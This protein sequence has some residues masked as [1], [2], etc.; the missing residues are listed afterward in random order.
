MSNNVKAYS[1]VV[2]ALEYSPF[3][4]KIITVADVEAWLNR[5][6][7]LGFTDKTRL[8]E[9]CLVVEMQSYDIESVYGTDGNFDVRV[10][11]TVKEDA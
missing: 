10:K 5:V 3:E 6:K 11:H 4:D 1:D 2:I 9:C 7:D 8:T